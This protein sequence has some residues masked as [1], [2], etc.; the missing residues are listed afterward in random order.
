MKSR[1]WPVCV[2]L[3]FFLPGMGSSQDHRSPIIDVHMHPF[4]AALNPDGTPQPIVCVN[5]ILDCQNPPSAYITN[6]AVLSGTIEY[7]DRYNI[8]L[9][10]LSGGGRQAAWREA[11]PE[12]FLFGFSVNVRNGRP[13]P[14][15]AR[16]A[17]ERGEY[18]LLGELGSQYQGLP[19]ND[20]LLEPYWALAEDLDIPVL[21]HALGIGGRRGQ[22][23]ADLGQ[24]LFLEDVLQAHPN[25]RLQVENAG[26]PFIDE[27]IAILY[28]YP[29]VYVDLSTITWIITREEFHDYLRRL[30]RAG[31]G[32]RVMF[33]SDQMSW[34]ETIGMAVEA[35]ESAEFLTQA[36]KRDIFFNNAVRFY[37]LDPE[38]LLAGPVR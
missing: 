12:R 11:E 29:N 9:G 32:E 10:V 28:M 21:I 5:D 30:I 6:E 1:T 22:F 25:L 2:L 35:I 24:P 19:P 14:D 3:S 13:H 4:G 16:A 37:R 31:Y 17:V 26:Y 34:P 38:E 23:R 20:P 33:G 18:Q 7:M 36:Q 27:M 8:V 15:S